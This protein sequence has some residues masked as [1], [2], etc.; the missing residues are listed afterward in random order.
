MVAIRQE[1]NNN[2]YLNVKDGKFV[3]KTDKTEGEGVRQRTFFNPQTQTQETVTE[4]FFD[5]VQGYIRECKIN[6]PPFGGKQVELTIEDDKSEK[7]II[8]FMFGDDKSLNVYARSFIQKIP[9]IDV[10]KEV[11]IIPYKFLNKEKTAQRGKDIYMQGFTVYQDDVKLQSAFTMNN[12]QGVPGPEKTTRM[13]EEK[14]DFSK[15]NDF[16]YER[17]VEFTEKVV[18]K[19][20]D[21]PF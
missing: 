11:V 8:Q 1:R 4:E 19:G 16:L 12:P 14:L 15:Q 10:K 2:L 5:S 17:L 20:S 9:A 18:E 21:L 6:T 3:R 13:G 7:A